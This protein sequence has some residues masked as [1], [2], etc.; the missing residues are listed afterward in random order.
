MARFGADRLAEFDEVLL[1]NST[2]FGPVGA[3]TPSSPTWTRADVDFWGITEHGS[4]DAAPF[5]RTG[6]ARRAHPVPLDRVAARC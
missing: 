6:H 4:A 2:F 3:S 1:M 5:E